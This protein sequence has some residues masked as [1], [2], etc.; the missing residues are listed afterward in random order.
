MK[1][2]VLTSLFAIALAITFIGI[3][4]FA[5]AQDKPADN[6]EI[7]KEKIRTDKKLFIATNMQLT[8]SEATAFW[9]VY[10]AYQA[11]LGKLRDREIKLIEK[12][13]ASYETMS[14]DVA[15][16]LLDDSL[17]ID[18]DH[19]KL[20]QSYLAKFRG[21]LPDAKVARYYQIE[22]KIDAV[23]EYELAKRIPLVR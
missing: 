17:S 6:M 16:N 18:S 11:E 22:S 21:V 10:E 4:D 15:K 20:R 9:P 2:K 19:Q 1:T 23:L 14:D 5:P 13:A 3:A 7:V 8:E 12:F